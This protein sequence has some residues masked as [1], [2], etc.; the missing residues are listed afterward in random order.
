MD[1]LI[2][3]SPPSRRAADGI[4]LAGGLLGTLL[5]GADL[6]LLGRGWKTGSQHKGRY[7]TDEQKECY[8]KETVA[9]L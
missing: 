9:K 2:A 7:R 8:F 4:W 1:S 6:A 5:S 3:F